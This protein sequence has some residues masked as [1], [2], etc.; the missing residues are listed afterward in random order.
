MTRQSKSTDVSDKI[1]TEKALHPHMGVDGWQIPLAYLISILNLT[2]SILTSFYIAFT[3]QAEI[4]IITSVVIYQE[5]K[6]E[7]LIIY[8]S[9][10]SLRR[11]YLKIVERSGKSM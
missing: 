5:M 9:L 11:N 7:R 6:G 8:D 4:G 1:S 3:F 2:L 10:L